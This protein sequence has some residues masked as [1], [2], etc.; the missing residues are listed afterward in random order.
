[1]TPRALLRRTADR[2]RSAG[3][4]DP[5]TDS[6]LLLSSLCGLSP[7]MLRVDDDT[8]LDEG[9]LSRMEELIRRRLERRPLQYLLGETFFCGRRFLS[10]PR[11][12]IPRPETELLCEWAVSLFNHRPGPRIL[13]LCCGSG[14]IG[15]TLKA[16][17]PDAQV[18]LSDLSAEALELA[19][20]NAAQLSLDVSFRQGDLLEPFAPGTFDLIA[21]NPP[22]IPSGDCKDLQPELHFEPFMALDGGA[23]GL[24]FYR[25]VIPD[26]FQILAPGG[27]LLME[28][29]IHESGPVCEMFLSAGFRSTE[30]RRDY[31][32]IDR[33]IL[34]I[35]P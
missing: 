14:C 30:I 29:G 33:M 6:A 35:R 28:L 20:K 21:C 10:D 25:R 15:L 31:A 34:G 7:L 3:I 13:D 4:P 8:C 23:D 27:F 5:E 1:M 18:T 16:D 19:R 26:A 12:L 32:Q 9:I 11:A 24:S 17:L 22:Y 2:F